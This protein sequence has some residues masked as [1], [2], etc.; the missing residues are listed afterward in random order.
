[1]EGFAKPERAFKPAELNEL[2]DTIEEIVQRKESLEENQKKISQ[3]S[4]QE[5]KQQKGT[6]ELV[7]KRTMETVSNS[8]KIKLLG[9]TKC[10][11]IIW[12]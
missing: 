9:K 11:R 4:G 6:A 1:M 8:S 2:D 7:R 10:K 3:E 12:R 5:L